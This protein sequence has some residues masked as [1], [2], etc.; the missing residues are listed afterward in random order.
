RTLFFLPSHFLNLTEIKS[1][2]NLYRFVESLN[3]ENNNPFDSIS[4][5]PSKS[6]PNPKTVT[7]TAIQ[8]AAY[9]GFNPIYLIGCDTSYIIPSNVTFENGVSDFLISN[10]NNDPNHFSTEYFGSGKKW[11]D[12]HVDRMFKQYEEA[13]IVYKSIGLDIYNA[14]VGGKLEVFPRVNYLDLF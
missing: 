13:N 11:H 9:L 4:L 6:I 8:L 1:H 14:T 7:I 12:P 3:K 5:D 10:E 2:K